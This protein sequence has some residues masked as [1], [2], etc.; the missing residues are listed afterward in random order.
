MFPNPM[1]DE[2]IQ[3]FNPQIKLKFSD[4]LLLHITNRSKGESLFDY[5]ANSPCLVLSLI[6]VTTVLYKALTR[7]VKLKSAGDRRYRQL[8]P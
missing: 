8:L 1:Y 4:L 2:I 5:Q 6:L 7:V 3:S